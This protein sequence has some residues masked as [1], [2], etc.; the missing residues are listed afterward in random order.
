MLSPV[1]QS[2]LLSQ[3]RAG[4]VECLSAG[5]VHLSLTLHEEAN[6]LFFIKTTLKKPATTNFRVQCQISWCNSCYLS[7][8]LT[9]AKGKT[10]SCPV[11]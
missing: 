8:D 7:E 3:P 2:L 1:I 6:T 11:L 4:N 5:I 10:L 9:S